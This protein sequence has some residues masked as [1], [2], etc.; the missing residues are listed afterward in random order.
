MPIIKITQEAIDRSKPPADG[1]H[2]FKVEKFVDAESKDKK[3]HNYVFESVII[4][5]SV[6]E[7]NLGRYGFAR[8][9]SKAPGMLISSGFLPALFDRTIEEEFDFNPEELAGKEF[10]GEIR[11]EIY[12]GK[13]QKKMDVFA[14]ATK[15]PF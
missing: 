9:N 15:P 4:K 8:F 14:P 2:L 10:W 11:S 5:S 6:S 3:S 7:E 12:E 13:M 1:W